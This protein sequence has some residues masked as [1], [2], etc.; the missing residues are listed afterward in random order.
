M[1]MTLIQVTQITRDC[2]HTK[3]MPSCSQL[4]LL[5]EFGVGCLARKGEDKEQGWMFNQSPAE[6]IH[7]V[8]Y[9]KCCLQC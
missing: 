7:K 1:L 2:C 3:K 9:L 8:K 5:S 6:C 4:L